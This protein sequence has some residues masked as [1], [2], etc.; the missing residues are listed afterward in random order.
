MGDTIYKCCRMC[1][2]M[3]YSAIYKKNHLL[4]PDNGGYAWS[5]AILLAYA[6][7]LY[8]DFKPGPEPQAIVLVSFLG[9]SKGRLSLRL[10]LL[11]P[12]RQRWSWSDLHAL[13][14]VKEAIT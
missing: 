2:H 7:H 6:S 14:A 11:P 12:L 13:Q 5:S 1:L 4:Q 8:Y 3:A 9:A 10:N